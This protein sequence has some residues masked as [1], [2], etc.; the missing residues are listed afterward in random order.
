MGT[1]NSSTESVISAKTII[2]CAL[3]YTLLFYLN[4]WLTAFL[5][6]APGVNWIYRTDCRLPRVAATEGRSACAH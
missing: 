3:T 4:D 2:A 1:A 5:E 6:A